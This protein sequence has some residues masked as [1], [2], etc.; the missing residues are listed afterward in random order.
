MDSEKIETEKRERKL[1]HLGFVKVITFNAV[2]LVSNLYEYAKQNSGPLRST[3]GTVENAV[4]TVVKPVYEKLKDVP[5]DVL[6]F[7]DKKVDVATETFNERAPPMVKTL[8]NQAQVI[9]VSV[10]HVAQ[11]LINEARLAGPRAAINH[12]GQ[13]SKQFGVNQLAVIWYRVNLSPTLHGVAV[14]AAS[15]AAHGSEKYNKLIK[16]MKAK[17]YDIFSYAPLVPVEEICK[18]Y[19]QVE[20]TAT[21]KDDDTSSESSTE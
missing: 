19:K 12:A 18:A 2:V 13:M 9:V 6:V 3:V 11:D 10:S 1:K 16:D 5:D 14:V 15:M 17:G 20:A 4:T 21:K 8:T 7:L